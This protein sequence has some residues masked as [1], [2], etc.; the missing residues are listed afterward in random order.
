MTFARKGRGICQQ[1]LAKSRI[2]RWGIFCLLPC[3]FPME[4]LLSLLPSARAFA[5]SQDYHG[6]RWEGI[7]FANRIDPRAHPLS[8]P[9][10]H[11]SLALMGILIVVFSVPSASARI[12]DAPT[13]TW[14][15]RMA[16]V[17]QA[18]TWLHT[19]QAADGTFG[20]RTSDAVYVI[21]R[22]GENP[23]GPA[24]RPAGVSALDALRAQAPTYLTDAGRAGKFLR[25]AVASGQ[26]VRHFGGVDLVAR[27]NSFYNPA[28][29][30]Y[31]AGHL[32]FNALAIQG[33]AL[34]GQPISATTIAAIRG[35][36]HASGGWEWRIGG[37]LDEVDTTGM[38]LQ[39]L[40][41]SGVPASDSMFTHATTY[42][43]NAQHTDA[44]WSLLPDGNTSSN[45][46]ALGLAGLLAAQQN[47]LAD[48][49]VRGGRTPVD[50]L[51][52]LQNAD[53]SF[54]FQAGVPGDR[55]MATLDAINVLLQPFP[56][57][58]L[59]PPRA[60]LPWSA[61]R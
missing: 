5:G 38:V 11:L 9:W 53:G 52:A 33:L 47:P 56:G 15:L 16:A 17:T 8:R 6:Q 18:I 30:W 51:L 26:D 39:A 49:F 3:L 19:Q 20:A 31:H 14:P 46:T 27:V 2:T 55:L 37:S 1:V 29:G 54:D 34:A 41:A 13:N 32:Y 58:S 35:Q 48:P 57:D 24:W 10:S 22:A 50:T 61:T 43:A 21:A 12:A 4:A 36:Q 25:A 45:S 42:L 44:G 59:P 40:A 28:T 23:D 60:Y 7:V